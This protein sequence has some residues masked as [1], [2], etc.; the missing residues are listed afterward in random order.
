MW[1]LIMTVF[2]PASGQAA[3]Y[4]IGMFFSRGGCEYAAEAIAA[5]AAGEG[6]VPIGFACT[7]A[8]GS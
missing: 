1:L 7:E 6:L 2:S 5:R 3:D 4:R 8:R